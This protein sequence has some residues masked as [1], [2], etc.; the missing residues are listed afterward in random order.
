MDAGDRTAPVCRGQ[1]WNEGRDKSRMD[2]PACDRQVQGFLDAAANIIILIL[3][4][5]CFFVPA[6]IPEK[7]GIQAL[8]MQTVHSRSGE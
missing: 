7:A 2:L 3:L 5:K 4:D 1:V 8:V 6:V